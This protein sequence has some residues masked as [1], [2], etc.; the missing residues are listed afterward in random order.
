IQ[1]IKTQSHI[2]AP[3]K[4]VLALAMVVMVL[5]ASAAPAAADKEDCFCP[6]M[7]DKCMVIAG[8]TRD[9]CAAACT[10]GCHQLE[11]EGQ[12]NPGEFCGF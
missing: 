12:P 5:M 4:A 7:R 9:D 8:A 10:D 3:N 2:M 6:C 11:M 1:E